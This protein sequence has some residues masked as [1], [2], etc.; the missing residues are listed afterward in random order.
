MSVIFQCP[1]M[2]LCKICLIMI[3]DLYELSTVC[4]FPQLIP[5]VSLERIK[6]LTTGAL[7][8]NLFQIIICSK[9]TTQRFSSFIYIKFP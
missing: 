2:F 7:R 6:L 3:V 1:S 4:S 5:Y 8:A 9:K